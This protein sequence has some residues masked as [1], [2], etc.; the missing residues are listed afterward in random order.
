MQ[1]GRPELG[2]MTFDEVSLERSKGFVQALQEL[3]NLRP[4]LYSAA[5]Y[6]EKSY[7]RSEQKQMVVDNLK[8]Y[9]V[10]AL[11]NVVDHL[12][13]V[14]YKLTDLFEQQSSDIATVEQKISCLC[15]QILSC[16][17]FT[18]EECLR[19]HQLFAAT[20]KHRKHY[21][22]PKFV[23]TSVESSSRLQNHINPSHVEAK[24]LPHTSGTAAPKTLSWHLA[25]GSNSSPNRDP[26]HT[27]FWVDDSKA[28][29]RTADSCRLLEETT[30]PLPLSSYL[31]AA[32]RRPTINVASRTFAVMDPLEGTKTV[33][34]FESSNDSG[35]REV[36]QPP[37]RN[38]SILSALFPRKATMK[39]KRLLVS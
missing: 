23:G 14:A 20:P 16:Q 34:G 26:P 15:Q 22:L 28:F 17:A 24:P 2:A 7:L 27:A 29:E 1:Q 39:P 6:C 5:E 38:K 37:A 31:Q 8:E 4:Q 35:Q 12:G 36:C 19:Q 9:G 10:R 11:V 3:K 30:A 21:T 32:K 13:T 25:S 33:S 18:A